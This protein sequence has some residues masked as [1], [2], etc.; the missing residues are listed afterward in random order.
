MD[1]L[2]R[3][4]FY[5]E[6]VIAIYAPQAEEHQTGLAMN[7]RPTEWGMHPGELTGMRATPSAKGNALPKE[8]N[9][10]IACRVME[11]ELAHV[12]SERADD[13]T[14]VTYVEQALHRTP[15]RLLTTVQEQIDLAAQS[16]SRIVLGYGLCAN[17]IIGIT[18]RN[19]GLIIPRCHDCIA[20]FLGSPK[21]YLDIFRERPGTYYLTVGWLAEHQDPLGLIEEHT[22]RYGKKT[23]QWIIEE[24]LKHYTHIAL[25]DTG[26][27]GMA[28]LRERAKENAAVLK[29][30]YT[31]IPGSLDYFRELL[32]G[33]YPEDRFIRLRL[34]DRF[35]QEMFL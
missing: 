13:R 33:P 29:K 31:E 1:I 11:P 2:Y 16:A 26:I 23:A 9:R 12:A 32:Y 6:K 19:N 34:G 7:I 17:G 14:E 28:P 15:E 3:L 35:K 8:R 5:C 22:P 24:E 30:R 27:E 20:L 4:G 10:I 18:A 25:I 21:R